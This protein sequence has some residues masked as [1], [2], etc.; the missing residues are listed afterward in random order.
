MMPPALWELLHFVK[1]F[2][3]ANEPLGY[4]NYFYN[5]RPAQKQIFEYTGHLHN[6]EVY[7]W[8]VQHG[9]M[10]SILAVYAAAPVRFFARRSQEIDIAIRFTDFYALLIQLAVQKGLKVNITHPL[11][12]SGKVMQQKNQQLIVPYLKIMAQ[13]PIP[14]FPKYVC[15]SGL[16]YWP[17][18]SRTPNQNKIKMKNENQN[19]MKK[20]Q[21]KILSV[22]LTLRPYLA[23]NGE[24]N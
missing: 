20:E 13:V 14:V 7:S 9:T 4:I 6:K 15:S 19:K 18:K 12:A 17:K 5:K 23:G 1:L 3:L 11:L 2:I 24:L 10:D 22:H 16:K 8:G 21:N